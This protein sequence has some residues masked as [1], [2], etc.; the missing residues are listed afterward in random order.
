[1]QYGVSFD[2]EYA[3]SLKLDPME[4]FRSVVYDWKFK[5]VRLPVHWD[6]VEKT[7]GT[8]DFSEIDAYLNEAEKNGVKV[9]LAIGN[10]TPRWPECHS[11]EWAKKLSRDDYMVSLRRYM[12][13]AVERFGRHPALEMWQVENEPFLRFGKCIIL[14]HSE[15]KEEIEMVKGIDRDHPVLVADSGELSTWYFTSRAADYFG[16]TLYRVV[17]N[18]FLGYWNYDWVPAV[19]YRWKMKM[20]GRPLDKAFVVELQAEPWSPARPLDELPILEQERSMNIYRLKKNI[21]FAQRVGVSRTYLWGAEWWV[22]L[23]KNGYNNI[24]DYIS[25][26]N[27]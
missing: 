20:V 25:T 7:E 14:T 13:M 8:F 9:I 11:P 2:P 17:W 3:G 21:D 26:L 16:T 19:I 1:M 12:K 23:R 15:L 5:S 10:K 27:R 22:W 6:K 24:P 18:R 4:A